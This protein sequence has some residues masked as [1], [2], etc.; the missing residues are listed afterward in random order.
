[1]DICCVNGWRI[2][3][4]SLKTLSIIID[5]LQINCTTQAKSRKNVQVWLSSCVFW[6]VTQNDR[7]LSLHWGKYLP[8]NENKY[9]VLRSCDGDPLNEAM[10]AHF[11]WPPYRWSTWDG[12]NGQAT[13]LH[14]WFFSYMFCMPVDFFYES[15]ELNIWHIWHIWHPW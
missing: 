2:G 5:V 14:S 10:E 1:M 8:S 13:L 9:R 15:F 7:L 12:N 4:N 3:Y 11:G 6:T